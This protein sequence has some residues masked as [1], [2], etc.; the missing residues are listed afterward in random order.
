[1]RVHRILFVFLAMSIWPGIPVPAQ[2]RT[3]VADPGAGPGQPAHYRTLVGMLAPGDTLLLP[4][5]AY[6][7]RL[8][9]DGLQGTASAWIVITGPGSG[10]PATITTQSTC[11]NTVQMGGTAY[12]ALKNL[13]I[14][15]AGLPAIDGI[16]AKG[17]PT[18]DILIERCTLIGQG[19]D[20]STI[21]ISTK[22]PAWRWTVRENRIIEAGSGMYFGNSDGTQPFIA[23]VIEGNLFLNSIGYN[24]EIKHQVPYQ[25]E[26]WALQVPQGSHRTVIRNNVFIKERSTWPPG[27]FVAPRPNLLV[28]AFPN[29]GMGSTDLYEIYGNF[30][31]RNPSESLLQAAGRL[32]LHDNIFVASAP[33]WPSAYLTNH[34][35]PLKLAHVYN[36]TVYSV[37]GEGILFGASAQEG[38]AVVGNL[39]VTGGT[40]LG[41]SIASASGNLTGPLANAALYFTRPSEV[42]GQM[43][44]YPRS[45]CPG[46]QGTPLAMA[47]FAGESDFDRDF[48]GTSKGNFAYRGAY[49]GDGA[50]PGWQ[51]QADLKTGAPGYTDTDPPAPPADVRPR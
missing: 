36:N 48:N 10:P 24:M 47:P 20:Q 6:R 17:N 18:H 22:S 28:D 13:T 23:G 43:D 16:N 25:S 42:L 41:G 8:D 19:Y 40:A 31:Y 7:D 21:G 11:C 15:S 37:A 30:F 46:C 45:D 51:L 14:D 38:D 50:N 33:G 1:M 32:T 34:N 2:A 44:F 5:G 12:V 4:A 26:S 3:L 35:G 9:L 27:S 29:S 39:I 49:A